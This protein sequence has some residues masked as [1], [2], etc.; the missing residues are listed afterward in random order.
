MSKDRHYSLSVLHFGSEQV[1][2][3]KGHFFPRRQGRV[4]GRGSSNHMLFA[5]ELILSI[6]LSK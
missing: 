6:Y 5:R 4:S 2:Q 1:D 3:Y